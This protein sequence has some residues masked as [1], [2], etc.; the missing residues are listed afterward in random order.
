MVEF[1]NKWESH[2]PQS[3]RY[4]SNKRIGRQVPIGKPIAKH[5]GSESNTEKQEKS[6]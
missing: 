6:K 3:L 1:E 4:G 5:T 2:Y